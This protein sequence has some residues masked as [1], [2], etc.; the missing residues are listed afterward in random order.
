M[1]NLRTYLQTQIEQHFPHAHFVIGLSGGV[2]SVVLLHLFRQLNV[3]VRA[4]HI[5]HGLS[6]N[7][8]SWADFCHALCQRWQI[9]CVVRKVKV[10]GEKGVEGNAR[11]ARYQALGEQI[12]A[13]EILVTA[14]HLDDQAETF[15]LALKRGSGVKG[16]S[17]MQA[18]SYR[19]NLTLFRP[20]L[21]ISKA[22]LINYAKQQDLL[23]IQDESNQ[24]NDFDRNFLRNEILPA[25]NQRWQHFNQMIARSAQHCAEQ[26][27]LLEELLAEELNKFADVQ[28]KSLN[29]AEFPYFSHAKQKQ[30]IRLWLTRHQ[31]PMPT[32]A[33]L[34]QILEQLISAKQDKNP[35]LQLGKIWLRR[36]QQRIFLTPTLHDFKHFVA[37]LKPHQ[38]LTLPDNLGQLNHL[39]TTLSFKKNGQTTRLNLPTELQQSELTI[40]LYHSGKVERYQTPQREDIKKL[41]QQAQI[42]VWERARTVLVFTEQ[43]LLYIFSD[44]HLKDEK[45]DN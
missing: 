7:A 16:L 18:V 25:L 14:H 5:H 1:I 37:T 9:P 17:A 34:Q 13:D 28:R 38:S 15:L 41:Y 3:E 11:E 27:T 8:D 31:I 36:Y 26:Q 43:K 21:G 10:Q 39:Q 2:D 33:Q 35:Q 42:P 6:P 40:K 4:I 22:D 24:I 12:Q 23:Y 32:T 45:F 19:Q 30:L 29:I 44:R 20:L